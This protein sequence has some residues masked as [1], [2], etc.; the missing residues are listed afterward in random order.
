MLSRTSA[1]V[2]EQ[3]EVSF[4]AYFNAF[5]MNEP[6]TVLVDSDLDWGQDMNRVGKRLQELGAKQVAFNPFIVAYLNPLHGFPP[7]QPS[8]PVNPSPGWKM[9]FANIQL[10]FAPK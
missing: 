7:I 9:L 5:A 4:A 10:H 2:P 3:S 8:D 1:V 6:E